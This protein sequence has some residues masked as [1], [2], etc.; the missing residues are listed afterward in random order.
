M[1]PFRNVFLTCDPD[2]IAQICRRTEIGKPPEVE[3][4]NIFGPTI[5]GGTGNETRLYRK[6]TAPAFNETMMQKAWN[7]SL[8]GSEELMQIILR[9]Q[10]VST[11]PPLRTLLAR[12]TLHVLRSLC[13]EKSSYPAVIELQPKG[14]DLEAQNGNISEAMHIVLDNFRTILGIPAVILS[15]VNQVPSNY[16]LY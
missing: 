13:F 16:R 10:Q 14:S 2:A 11:G 6:L 7:T 4:L 12:L 15:A 1:S 5:T 8:S 3:L 9:D